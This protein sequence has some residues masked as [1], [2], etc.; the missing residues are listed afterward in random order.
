MTLKV[1]KVIRMRVSYKEVLWHIYKKKKL[2]FN[3]YRK[4]EDFSHGPVAKTPR[5]ACRGPSFNPLSGN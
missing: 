2:Y 4:I 1:V 3:N 5:S